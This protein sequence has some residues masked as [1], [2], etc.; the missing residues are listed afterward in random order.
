MWPKPDTFQANA[1]Q[2]ADPQFRMHLFGGKQILTVER[3]EPQV[4]VWR[5]ALW[6]SNPQDTNKPVQLLSAPPP[7]RALPFLPS[8]KNYSDGKGSL[9]FWFLVWSRLLWDTEGKSVSQGHHR[10]KMCKNSLSWGRTLHQGARCPSTSEEQRCRCHA[11][12][13]SGKRY[14]GLLH[15]TLHTPENPCVTPPLQ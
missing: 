6:M 13:T 12:V 8:G 15:I 3:K 5:C 7:T 11:G 1:K 10:M 2:E 14:S 9:M 4:G